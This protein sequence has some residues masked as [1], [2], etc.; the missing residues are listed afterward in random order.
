MNPTQRD[1][2]PKASSSWTDDV[3]LGPEPPRAL[4]DPRPNFD[5]EDRRMLQMPAHNM[6]RVRRR[7]VALRMGS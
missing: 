2:I 4:Q 7:T 3:D 1:G 6:T 5:V